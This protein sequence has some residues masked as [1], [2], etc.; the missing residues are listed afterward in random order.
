MV[1]KDMAMADEAHDKLRRPSILWLIAI[2]LSTIFLMGVVAGYLDGRNAKGGEGPSAFVGG[3]LVLLGGIVVMGLYLRRFG[4][5]WQSWSRRKRLYTT[6]IFG[7]GLLG[8]IFAVLISSG[9]SGGATNPFFSDS[10]LSP[11]IAVVLA[12]IWGVGISIAVVA[13]QRTVDDHERHAYLWAGLAG[14][15]AFVIPAPAWWVLARADLVP[16]MNAMMLF[17]LT[18]IVNAVVYLWLKFR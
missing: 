1:S 18:M 5:F 15:Y 12:L 3:A 2:A 7:S 13:Y 9:Q 14:Y 6:S 4:S 17:A 11:Q 16:P 10:A 8:L